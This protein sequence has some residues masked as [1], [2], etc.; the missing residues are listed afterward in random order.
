MRAPA[1]G[2]VDP[3]LTLAPSGMLAVGSDPTR[4]ARMQRTLIGAD[5][6]FER[7]LAVPMRDG[8]VLSANLF[9][10]VD[11]KPAPVIMSVRPYGKDT[12]RNPF[13]TLLMRLGGVDSAR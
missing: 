4:G 12:G 10:P 11:G 1:C 8:V 3:E 7:D 9:R 6:I 5:V 13:V 2:A